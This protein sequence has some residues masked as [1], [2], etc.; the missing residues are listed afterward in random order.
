MTHICVGNLTII[1]SDNGLSP[2]RHQAIIWTNVGMMLIGPLGTNFSEILIEIQTIS[3]K[4]KRLK[5]LSAKWRPFFFFLNEF[6]SGP[7]RVKYRYMFTEFWKS[8]HEE[9][10]FDPDFCLISVIYELTM[11]MWR[12]W[13]ASLVQVLA[14]LDGTGRLPEPTLA[15]FQWPSGACLYI[16]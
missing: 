16:I 14:A 9:L 4:K 12:H 1:G 6:T 3:F 10:S 11:A 5:V 7:V 8:A 15:Y 13:S 2:G